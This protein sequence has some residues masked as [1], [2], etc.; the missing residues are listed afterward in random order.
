MRRQYLF[1]VIT[2]VYNAEEYLEETINSVLNQTI[3]FEENIQIIFVNDGSTDGSAAIC[4]KYRDSFPDN[5]TYIEKENGGVSSARNE[6]LKHVRGKY[7]VFLDSDDIWEKNAFQKIAVFFEN[8]WNEIDV[9]SCKMI[10]IGDFARRVHPLD[11]KFSGENRIIDLE[12]EPK[13]ICVTIGNTVFKSES[14]NSLHFEEDMKYCEDS[15]FLNQGIAE[16]MKLGIIND[17]VFSYR[18]NDVGGNASRNVVRTN[19]WYFDI[20]DNYYKR[21]FLYMKRKFDYIPKVFQETIFYDI[22]WRGY[23]EDIINEFT[24]EQK[25]RHLEMLRGVLVDID[26]DI[27]LNTTGINVFKKIYFLNVKHRSNI[28]DKAVLKDGEYVYNNRRILNLKAKQMV[29]IRVI[30]LEKDILTISG[31]I[32]LSVTGRPYHFYLKEEG[33][34][35]CKIDVEVGIRDRWGIRGV[36]GEKIVDGEYFTV[37]VKVKPGSIISLYTDIDGETIRLTPR[38]D[39]KTRLTSDFNNS[40][41]IEEDR[42]VRLSGG[43]I[44]ILNNNSRNRVESEARLLHSVYKRYGMAKVRE[45][46]RE[47]KEDRKHYKAILEDK[48]LFITVRT[49]DSLLDNMKRVYDML[50]MP[51]VMFAKK[52]LSYRKTEEKQAKELI[53][54]SKVVVTDDY[55]YLMKHKKKGQKYVQLWHAAGAGKYFGQDGT[56]MFLTEDA[57]YHRNYDLVTVSA[58]D[59]RAVYA[60]AFAIPTDKVCATGIART[61]AF[62]D[63]DYIDEVREK[64]YIQYPELKDK[65]VILYTPTFRDIPGRGRAIFI[66]ELDFDCLSESL[67]DDQVFI[68]RPHPVM[69][70]E[71]LN[72]EYSNIIE[73]RDVNTNDLMFISDLLVTDYSSTM[74]EYSLLKKP[75]VFFCYDYDEYDRDFYLDFEHELPGPILK[76]QNELLEYLG[77]DSYELMPC[78][79]DF[80]TKNMSACDGHSTERIVDLIKKMVYQHD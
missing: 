27:I 48:V 28:L 20:I 1:S 74:F 10:Y 17:A 43:K 45:V 3:G 7:T 2:P 70:K 49:E 33:Q 56:N 51:K 66:P 80:Y 22:K 52:K 23:K 76:T 72:H 6:A 59:V 8:H 41:Y 62:F 15:W 31:L 63:N 32:R 14:I 68:V 46:L 69:A 36:I 60:S 65:Q 42:I 78:Y 64:I 53:S 11:F 34:E 40:F 55:L 16:K 61:D 30:D 44:L 79:Y 77:R 57:E 21:M 25:K 9:C 12:K 24:E 39:K 38:C 13:Y 26:D 50:D 18:K 47:Q 37:R 54:S 67:R 75:M 5:I 58:E 73:I 19:A 29:T 71:I 35:D 4:E